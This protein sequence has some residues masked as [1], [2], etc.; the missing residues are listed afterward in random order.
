MLQVFPRLS[1]LKLLVKQAKGND[2]SQQ[3]SSLALPLLF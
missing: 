1:M 3:A 2:E